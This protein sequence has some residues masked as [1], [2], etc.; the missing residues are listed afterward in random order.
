MAD[1]TEQ[2][3]LGFNPE[4]QDLSRQ[5]KIAEMLMASGMQ[6]P[7]G[8]MIS[9]HYV[10]PSWTQQLNPLFNAAIGSASANALDEK[11]L[12]LADALRGK[13]QEVIDQF[14]NAT[15]PQEQLKAA[16]S[17]Y[18][19]SWLQAAGAD[20]LKTQKV[21][22]GENLSRLNF[23]TNKYET[24]LS[25][26][27]KLPPRMKE[28]SLTYGLSND[29]KEWTADQQKLVANYIPP[30][31]R[32]GLNMR[33]AELA[34]QGIGGYGGGGGAAAPRPAMPTIGQGSPILAKPGMPTAQGG[35]VIPV[36]ATNPYEDFNKSIVPPA[37]LPPRDQRKW[38]A[39]ANS[40]LTGEAAKQ[41]TGAIN[42]IS[43]IDDY[44]NLVSEATRSGIVS[45]EQRAKLGAA[46][47]TMNLNA[48]EAYNLG[49]LNGDD[50][51]LINSLTGD[52]NN[53]KSLL[54]SKE[55]LDKLIEKQRNTM[56]ATVQNVYGTQQKK[57]PEY[58]IKKL[59]PVVATPITETQAGK[60]ERP[61]MI[62]ETTWGFMTPQEKALFKR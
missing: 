52:I 56:G 44:R 8:Q 18:A 62:D 46:R 37:G 41:V 28:A 61:S 50:F 3:I 48:K 9:G 55:T 60:I 2:Q 29:P 31:E 4:I 5:R 24:I 15:T 53:P 47:N 45:P 6:Q 14:A 40:P 1:T 35:A 33:G 16:S 38:M 10:A 19:P 32:I 34:D 23:G 13:Q 20:L 57:I 11:Q 43:A 59:N 30:A 49:V 26:G 39:E 42:T 25:G 36:V 58:V 12:K 7:Q 27:A 51:K 17:Q 54:L 22:E 21:G